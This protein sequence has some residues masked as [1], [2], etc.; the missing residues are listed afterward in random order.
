M[1]I[2]LHTHSAASDGTQSPGDLVREAADVGV[3]VLGLT[4]HDTTAGWAEAERAALESG[5]ALVRG[6][7]LSTR[8]GATSVHLLSYLHDPADVPLL[9]ALER[10]RTARVRRAEAIVANLARDVDLTW[11]DVA[12][13]VAPGATVGRPHIADALVAAGAAPS[14]DAVFAGLLGEGSPYVV[15]Y[16][17]PTP[18][19]MIG[20]VLAAGGVPVLAHPFAHLRGASLTAEQLIE[21]A[22]C[23]L[24]GVEV[25]HRDHAQEDRIALRGLARELDLVVTGSSDYHGTGKRNRLGENGTAPDQLAAVLERG[26]LPLVDGRPAGRRG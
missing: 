11:A 15:H 16:D 12:A 7:E 24:M 1:L 4:D 25:D 19:E 21:L 18:Q 14:R 5:I 2:D 22:A 9:A 10:S 13:Q 26:R 6:A 23:G 20:L 8:T 17:V 3:D